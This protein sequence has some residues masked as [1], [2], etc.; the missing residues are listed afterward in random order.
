[1]ERGRQ[2]M[3]AGLTRQDLRRGLLRKHTEQGQQLLRRLIVGRLA[4][5]PE[6][7]AGGRYY[8]FTGQGRY[9]RLL[10]GLWPQPR[11]LSVASPTGFASRGWPLPFKGFSDLKDE[12]A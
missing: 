8:L 1:V 10:A 5:S 3:R 7:D 12:A 9:S 6:K 2:I 4:L 11:I